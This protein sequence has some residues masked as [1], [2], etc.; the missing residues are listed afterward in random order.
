V[1]DLAVQARALSGPVAPA[2]RSRPIA[3][4]VVALALLAALACAALWPS[5]ARA[6]RLGVVSDLTWTGSW[7]DQDRAG[8]AIA[9]LGA[10]WAKL[11]VDWNRAEPAPGSYN[12]SLIAYYD[13]A[14]DTARAAG[15][16]VL[17]LVS[18]SPRWASGSDNVESPP[19]EPGAYGR[20]VG[21]LARRWAGKVRAYEIWNEPNIQRFWPSGP[22]ASEYVQ[23]LR[24]A[25]SSIKSSDPYARVVFG[26]VANLNPGARD[27]VYDAYGAGAENYFD[28]LGWHAYAPC[29]SSPSD[30][31]YMSDGSI[32]VWS[33]LGYRTIRRDMTVRWS[34]FKPIW[35][36]EF[37]WS[38]SSETCATTW[39]SGVSEDVQAQRL[40]EAA[41]AMNQDSYLQVAFWYTLRN[42]YWDAD[43]DQIEA[44][45]GLARS[46]W[47]PKPAYQA[48]RRLTGA[49]P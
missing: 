4:G 40:T 30:V 12:W 41:A 1:L 22:S 8:A 48:F 32:R 14:I 2:R 47:S 44:R 36:T 19:L 27:F 31:W 9:D 37:G 26:G 43:A 21:F 16:K 38:T 6:A 10:R 5:E 11:S 24:S 34:D 28:V 35:V 18:R 39:T 3:V 25:Y 20:F 45:F 13:R 33:F 23:L 29:G 17:M 7:D 15:A 42:H 46:D 49:A